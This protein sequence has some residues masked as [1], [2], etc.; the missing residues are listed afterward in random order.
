M[1]SGPLTVA[2]VA[3][4]VG[5]AA[6]GIIDR[7]AVTVG[8]QVITE[9]EVLRE[10]RL[11]E[12]ENGEPPDL[13]PAARRA[14][15]ERLVDQELIRREMHIGSYPKPT[16]EEGEA[17]LREWR[18]EH[19]PDDAEYSAA[20]AEYGVTEDELK[21]HLIWELAVL[22]FTDVR[23][24]TALSEPGQSADRAMNANETEVE[25]QLEAWLKQQR[26][27]TRIQF[28]KEAFQP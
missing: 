6:A 13:G 28:K 11:T 19:Y 17:M 25:R 9:S 20:L 3:L 1:G 27:S 14:A 15:A 7:I 16:P 24:K 10:A 18:R 22:R 12:I 21:Q 4:A 2:A 23:F 26:Q 5:V 8:N